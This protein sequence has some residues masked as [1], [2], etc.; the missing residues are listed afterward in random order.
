MFLGS[1]IGA[2]V[3]PN[4]TGPGRVRVQ[5]TGFDTPAEFC[6]ERDPGL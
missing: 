2:R 6:A 1:W 3:G 4:K 5:D